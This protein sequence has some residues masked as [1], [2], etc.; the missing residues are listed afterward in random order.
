MAENIQFDFSN[1]DFHRS[2]PDI[3]LQNHVRQK[4]IAL[5]AEV[6]SLQRI[7]LDLRFWILFR[8][9]SIGRNQDKHLTDLLVFLKASVSE[10]KAICPISE[11]IFIE[12]FKQND[13]SSKIATAQLIDELSL[14]VTLIRQDH[15]VRQELCNSFYAQAGVKELIPVQELVWTKLT[16][17]LGEVHPSNTQFSPEVELVIQKSF[18]DLLWNTRLTE[19]AE[20]IRALPPSLDLDA[21]AADLNAKSRVHQSA[22]RSYAQTFRVEFEGVLNLFRDDLNKLLE[23]L[24][25]R[26]YKEFGKGVENLSNNKRFEAFTLSIP[27][28]HIGA[29]CHAAVRWDKKRNLTSNDLFDFHHAEAALGYCNVFLTEKPLS[30][31]LSQHH[32]GLKKYNCQIFWSPCDALTCLIN[33]RY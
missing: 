5:G 28:L 2:N 19:I 17:V 16:Y 27:T 9:V 1:F 33:S 14:G 11:S 22:L 26:G 4:V 7:Y 13:K 12:L 10:G 30:I 24:V 20:K 21:L 23:E 15:R 6:V 3:S 25:Q 8:D 32:L 18:F 31:M 29:S